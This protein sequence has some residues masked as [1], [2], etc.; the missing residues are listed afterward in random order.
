MPRR[1]SDRPL[2]Q[3]IMRRALLGLAV[4]LAAGCAIWLE[5]VTIANWAVARVFDGRGFGPA[6]PGIE[7]V[8][9]H[10]VILRAVSLC[11]GALTAHDMTLRYDPLG[12]AASHVSAL[13]IDRAEVALKMEAGG[14]MLGSCPLSGGPAGGQ[15]GVRIDS[16]TLANARVTLNGMGG[17]A[18]AMLS[19]TLSIAGGTIEGRDL[20]AQISV[21]LGSAPRRARFAAHGFEITLQHAGGV[22]LALDGA[23]LTP[24][25]LPLEAQAIRGELDW[26]RDEAT[27]K[28]SVDRIVDRETPM[29]VAP[30]ALDAEANLVGP[31]LDVALH[32]AAGPTKVAILEAKGTFDRDV[33]RGSATVKFGPIAF[34]DSGLQPADLVPALRGTVETVEGTMSATGSLK[35]SGDRVS[36]DLLVRLQDLRFEAAGAKVSNL[37]GAVRITGLWPPA[38]APRQAVTA[39]V[40]LAGLPPAKVH[41]EGQLTAKPALAL[42][43][44]SLEL[45]GGTIAAEPFD[46]DPAAPRIDT[47]ID[48]AGLDLGELTK[49]LAVDGLSGSGRLSG[50][51][52]LTIDRGKVT[53]RAGRLAAEAPGVLR[54]DPKSPPKE[55][56][57]AGQAGALALQAL[58]DFHYDALTL[59]LDKE[60]GGRGTVVIHLDGRNPAVMNGQA[61]RFNI[62][63]ESNFDRLAELAL[64]NL[65]SAQELLRQAVQ[66]SDK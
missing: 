46:L 64:L 62:Q 12:L 48:I 60:V 53:V 13:T 47:A 23:S 61:F 16:L 42:A 55:I 5:R 18:E 39:T 32:A 11:G 65:E 10:S 38:T 19:A 4:L 31:R 2:R 22:R 29:R 36:P 15:S 58:R 52:P 30:V 7:S 6:R 40:A 34:R 43:T 59:E 26:Q 50:R 14:V 41:V 1:S 28:L 51:V 9:F 63:L 57:A 49:L 66:R 44:A 25:D 33:S 56:D 8:G 3:R 20:A 54:Y 45:A 17:P 35:F 37:S 21:P 24:A 27:A